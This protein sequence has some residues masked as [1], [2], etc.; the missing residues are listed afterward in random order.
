MV[1]VARRA[2]VSRALVSL[3]LSGKPGASPENRA[4]VMA[5]AAELGYAPDLYARRLRQGTNRLIGVVFD[6]HDA[7][8]ARVLDAAHEAVAEMGYDLVLTMSS[9]SVPLARALRTLVAQRVRAVLLI[10]S[11]PV[12]DEAAVLLNAAPAVFV[13]A[14]APSRL[15]GRVRSVHSDDDVGMRA[16]V[17]HLV[18]LGHR[19]L[20]V[21]RVAGRRSGDVRADAVLDEAARL[22]ARA[23]E[24]GVPAYDESAGVAAGHGVLALERRPTAVAA[25]NDALALGVIHV[26]RRAGLRVPEDV[27]VTG[28]DDAGSGTTPAVSALGLTTVRQDVEQIVSSALGLLDAVGQTGAPDELVLPTELVLRSTTA[29]PPVRGS[30]AP[31]AG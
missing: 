8:T 22:G 12:D 6:G 1:D 26:L 30:T 29:P 17:R 23:V 3:V 20:A 15:I 31:E 13:G 27:S 25:A 16:V 18:G 24:I 5:A 7:F 4:R 28:F 9:T 11:T 21:T 14:Y 10:S 2:G 19:D